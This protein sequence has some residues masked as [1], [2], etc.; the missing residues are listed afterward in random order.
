MKIFDIYAEYYNLLYAEKN[1]EEEVDYIDSLIKR[2]SK[3]NS[4]FK[5]LLD[6]G[7]GTGKH[8]DLLANK[9]YIVTGIDMSERMIKEAKKLEHETLKFY[10]KDGKNF[11]LN[12]KFDVI[13]S[14][15]H[16]ASYQNSNKD[17]R[18]YFK[19]VFSHLDDN[20][21][22]IFDFWYGP[23]VLTDKP[24]NRIKR[25]ENK[26]FKLTR[27]TEPVLYLNKNLVEVNYEILIENKHD[28]NLLKLNEKHVMRYFF[29]PELE[30][31][32][33]NSGMKIVGTFEWMTLKEPN[34]DSWYAVIIAKK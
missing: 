31:L 2:Y 3:N 6:I 11:N 8:A 25:C 9:S 18:E 7:C 10:I 1:Y 30:V 32:L 29:M 33:N 13:T 4:V 20:G 21:I 27:I 23:A 34:F 24:S 5:N 19:C 17:I 16:V 12:S 26:I 28:D 15:F 14:L 22:F